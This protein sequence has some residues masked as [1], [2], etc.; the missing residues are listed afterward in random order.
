MRCRRLS[1]LGYRLRLQ[2]WRGRFSP[3]EGGKLTISSPISRA[4][5]A[6]FLRCPNN[7]G[8]GFDS[9]AHS[10]P[11]IRSK[12]RSQDAGRINRALE[13]ASDSF[14]A[15]DKATAIALPMVS[16]AYHSVE[17]TAVASRNRMRP[18]CRACA[19]CLLL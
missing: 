11:S 15:Q 9:T 7:F 13:R 12:V 10:S 5:S 1:R 3:V 18:L 6:D 16:H 19:T 17:G 4:N 2:F 8:C 14:A